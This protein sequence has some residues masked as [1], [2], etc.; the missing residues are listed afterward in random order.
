MFPILNLKE[1]KSKTV[2]LFVISSDLQ[3][4]TEVGIAASKGITRRTLQSELE[5]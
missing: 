2:P 3:K 5:I 1:A 4:L